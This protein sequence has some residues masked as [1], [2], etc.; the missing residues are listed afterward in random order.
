MDCMRFIFLIFVWVTCI[1]ESYGEQNLFESI[2]SR[3]GLSQ[4]DVISIF[5]DS[6]GFMWFGTND[7]INRYDGNNLKIYRN[8]EGELSSGIISDVKED[9]SKKIWISTKDNGINSLCLLT[10]DIERYTTENSNI[11]SN[12]INSIVV[13]SKGNIWY[14]CNIGIGKLIIGN[15]SKK[16]INITEP[17]SDEILFKKSKLFVDSKDQIWIM[18]HKK[19]SKIKGNKVQKILE[20]ESFAF[21]DMAEYSDGYVI[22]TK[23]RAFIFDGKKVN[24]KNYWPKRYIV[25]GDLLSVFINENNECFIGGNRLINKYKYSY[26]SN[27]FERDNFF[28]DYKASIGGDKSI[29]SSIYQDKTGILF[30]GTVGDGVKKYNPKSKKF[31][32]YKLGK[33]TSTRKVRAIFEDSNSNLFIGHE[34]DSLYTLI[35]SPIASSEKHFVK[36]NTELKSIFS[37]AEIVWG[38]NKNTV[39]GGS[40]Y[41]Y[42][43]A[44]ILGDHLELP[45]ISS[46]VFAIKQTSNGLVWIGTYSKGIYRFDPNGKYP[47]KHFVMNGGDGNGLLS[48]TIRSICA[49]AKGRLWIGTSKGLNLLLHGEQIKDNPKFVG[50]LHDKDNKESLSHNYVLPIFESSDGE[51]WMGSMGGGLNRLIA[52]DKPGLA[53]FQRFTSDDGL[54]NNVIKSI[55]E[56]DFGNLWISTNRGISRLDLSTNKFENYDIY[57]GMQ[58][59][60]FSELCSWKLRTGELAFGGVNGINIFNPEE[61]TK[62]STTAYPAFTRLNVLN[63]EVTPGQELVNRVIM[64]QD[65]NHVKELKFLYKENSFSIE[66]ASLHYAYPLKNKC[67]YKLEGFDDEWIYSLTGNEAKYTNLKPGEYKFRLQAANSNG[68]WSNVEKVLPIYVAQPTYLS[69]PMK[70]V[71]IFFV[72]LILMFF[73]RFSVIRVKRKHELLIQELEKEKAEEINQMKF[74]FFTNISHE[75][76]TPLTLILSPLEQLVKS[77]T[78]PSELAIR[79]TNALMYRNAKVLLRLVNQLIDFRKIDKGQLK[80]YVQ[81]GNL[82]AFLVKIHESFMPLAIKKDIQFDFVAHIVNSKVLFDFDKLSKVI[83]NLLSNAFK[84]TDEGGKVLLE[85]LEDKSDKVTIIV[86]DNGCGIPQSLQ[87]NIYERFFQHAEDKSG[88]QIGSGIGLAY[89]KSLIE[90][91]HGEI[92]LKSQEGEG[93]V[94]FV[95]LPVNPSVFEPEELVSSKSEINYQ[96]LNS[97]IEHVYP[98]LILNESPEIN[99]EANLQTLLLVEDNNDLRTFLSDYFATSF[100]IHTAVNGADGFKKAVEYSPDIVVTDLAMPVMDGIELT[101]KLKNHQETSHIPVVMLTAQSAEQSYKQGL[102]SGADVYLTKPVKVDLLNAQI[103][104]LLKNREALRTKFKEKIELQ[105]SELSPTRKDESFLKKVMELIEDNVG[106]PEFTVQKLSVECGMSQTTLNVKL[107]ALT[108]QKAKI[109]IRSIRLKRAGQLLLQGE[110]TISE[111]TYSVGFNDLQYFRKCFVSEFGCLPS[112]YTGS[113]E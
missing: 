86:S 80:L 9:I 18:A 71:Y 5:Q 73:K 57:E 55:E 88:M 38:D 25:K 62:D 13:D 67:R 47:L 110:K 37:M 26:A 63:K 45:K 74:S 72:L 111:I 76:K 36:T 79:N 58:D 11:L 52:I 22:V 28:E 44:Y 32:H 108:G 70:T 83:T 65:I 94:F 8:G 112:D 75:F 31:S 29:I 87:S 77:K 10:G 91:M 41:S 35:S 4:N 1:M 60:E 66:F 96:T 6:D 21:V 98:D 59:Y 3:S 23:G 19:L 39:L 106:D 40:S 99:K 82:K 33:T 104:S 90:L 27:S 16:F 2:N 54:P 89:T 49:D 51:I 20:N 103:K 69:W 100:H 81:E 93:T 30:L 12:R 95:K 78:L 24:K 92:D 97:D 113:I 101:E 64:E 105:P 84:F 109:F 43:L 102:D 107:N 53:R 34:G 85:I 14:S 61:I 15:Q 56:D 42:G 50:F 68:V 48:N 17:N 7:G 46:R